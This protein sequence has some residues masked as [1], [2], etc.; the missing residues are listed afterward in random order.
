M[1]LN[2]PLAR[3]FLE[4]SRIG[5]Q[6]Q[7]ANYDEF[8]TAAAAF[9]DDGRSGRHDPEWVRQAQAAA[10]TRQAGGFQDY[11]DDMFKKHWAS[12]SRELSEDDDEEKDRR[13]RTERCDESTYKKLRDD[14]YEDDGGAGL[15]KG[16]MLGNGHTQP[17]SGDGFNYDH[18]NTIYGGTSN[19]TNDS[20]QGD[21]RNH[22]IVS[23]STAVFM[24]GGFVDRSIKLPDCVAD[25]EDRGYCDNLHS[26]YPDP[27]PL[28]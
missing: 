18:E 17:L 23:N 22:V 13:N 5:N 21:K 7:V 4:G 11:E 6:V 1:I 26:I 3:N 15:S 16:K 2:H 25:W 10:D 20:K 28:V 27:E 8:A 24:Y 19:Y 14:D 12:Q 9:K